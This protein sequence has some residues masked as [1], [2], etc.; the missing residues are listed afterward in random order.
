M[1]PQPKI[2]S[3][4]SPHLRRPEGFAGD[5]FVQSLQH[6]RNPSAF[7]KRSR[8]GAKSPG[9]P[10]YEPAFRRGSA[11]NLYPNHSGTYSSSNHTPLP[12]AVLPPRSQSL[13]ES[14]GGQEQ[15][16]DIQLRM[17]PQKFRSL[18]S[19][20]SRFTD[21]GLEL[22]SDFG[23]RSSDSGDYSADEGSWVGSIAS[24]WTRGSKSKSHMG[25]EVRANPKSS[26][27]FDHSLTLEPFS[28]SLEARNQSEL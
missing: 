4:T 1:G 28:R 25:A 16:V 9:P 23:N 21:M 6:Q 19:D 11:P 2:S 20:P 13:S 7:G 15:E 5:N 24:N 27:L 12:G 26:H 14:D 3:S 8:R 22:E 18:W 10:K 17:D